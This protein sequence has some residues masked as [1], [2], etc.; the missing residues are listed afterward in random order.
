MATNSLVIKDGNGSSSALSTFSGSYGLIPE[1]AVSGTVNVTASAASPVYVTGN[2]SISQPVNVDLN[3]SDQLTVV[4]SSSENNNAVWI[5]SSA[6][7]PA[8]VNI[9]NTAS[10]SISGTPTITGSVSIDGI[11]TI[12]GSVT[13]NGVPTVALQSNIVTAS[14]SGTPTITG[15]VSIDGT[16]TITGSVNVGS[17][18]SV[19]SVTSST[20]NPVYVS[21]SYSTP[22]TTKEK[23]PNTLT[24]GFF[25]AGVGQGIDWASTAS[26]NVSGTFIIAQSSSTRS[27]LMFTNNFQN[28][29]YVIY[30][31]GYY[32]NNGFGS[33]TSTASAPSFFSFILYPN[34]TYTADPAFVNVKHSGFIVS[35]SNISSNTQLSVYSTE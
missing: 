21:S 32:S 8:Y 13:I 30:D 33:L 7:Y 4:V 9:N 34:G 2:V 14:I 26:V 5:T 35:A 11:P 31:S 12:T 22:V 18:N 6:T 24:L 1:H 25:N 23:L 16:P 10:V 3:L 27:G 19:V 15:S 20:S 17:I 28:N 29:I